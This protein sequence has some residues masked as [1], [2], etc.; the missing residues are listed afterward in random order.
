M[1]VTICRS[2]N[3]VPIILVQQTIFYRR[4]NRFIEGKAINVSKALLNTGVQRV[5]IIGEARGAKFDN[6]PS[7]PSPHC[8]KSVRGLHDIFHIT[9]M[10]MV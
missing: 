10:K 3:R 7:E 4:H 5:F 6:L 8:A 9:R 2:A 1:V